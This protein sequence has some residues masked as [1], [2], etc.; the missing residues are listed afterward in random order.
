M[1][2]PD[3]DAPVLVTGG[4]GFIGRRLVE[5][6]LRAGRA[7]RVLALPGEAVPETWAQAVDVRRGD[8]TDPASV[9]PRSAPDR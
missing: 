5:R 1:S 2:E 9:R 3:A 6:L 8:L 7:V 4:T